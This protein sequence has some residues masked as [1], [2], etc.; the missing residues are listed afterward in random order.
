[1]KFSPEF[2]TLGDGTTMNTKCRLKWL[3]KMLLCATHAVTFSQA[4]DGRSWSNVTKSETGIK[5][6]TDDLEAII[7]KNNPKHWMTSISKGSFLVKV[8]GFREVGDGQMVIDWLMEAGS[9][10]D[11][12]DEVFAPDGHGV[13]SCPRFDN[14]TN[15]ATRPLHLL[16][17][18]N[19]HRKWVVEGLQLCHRM[20][21]VEPKV[22]HGKEFVAVETTY[23]YDYAGPHL[24]AESRWTQLI[25]FSKSRRCFLLMD[26]INSVNDLPKMF[27]RNDTPSCIRHEQGNTF[28]E[29]Y[30]SGPQEVRIP[31]SHFFRSFLPI[32]SSV[33]TVAHIEFLSI[34]F[35]PIICGTRKR[36]SLIPGSREWRFN[37]QS[38]TK[39][40]AV[41]G[42]EILSS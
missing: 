33:T 14:E 41:N 2:T 25:G 35:A 1:M 27:L 40:G 6:E 36:A 15:P 18:S 31:S 7:S 16:A 19:G 24:Q 30:L 10:E 13:G 26:K 28:S 22:I 20:K 21:P 39:P 34:S 29:P 11:Y 8:T 23:K 5:I 37:R 9:V 32:S 17:H 38:F 42:P 4:N 3:T 12:R